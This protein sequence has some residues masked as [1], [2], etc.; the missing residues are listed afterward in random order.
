MILRF[1]FQQN[2]KQINFLIFFWSHLSKV[3]FTLFDCVA[4]NW[5]VAIFFSIMWRYSWNLHI[6]ESYAVSLY[7]WFSI[8]NE[9]RIHCSHLWKKKKEIYLVFYSS[10]W[11][12]LMRFCCVICIIFFSSF[13]LFRYL[14]TVNFS[15]NFFLHIWK[16]FKIYWN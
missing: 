2:K 3:H 4:H 7:M 1:F 6:H 8:S 16:T 10:Y 5:E 11:P 12:K 15:L 14:A 9:S 13:F